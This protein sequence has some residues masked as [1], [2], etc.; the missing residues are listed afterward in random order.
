[1][2]EPVKCNSADHGNQFLECKGH[3]CLTLRI[4]LAIKLLMYPIEQKQR[5]E[6]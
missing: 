1:M 6:D 4:I 2:V 5:R 3:A